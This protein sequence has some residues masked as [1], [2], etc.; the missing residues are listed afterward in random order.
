VLHAAQRG[1]SKSMPSEESYT[2]KLESIDA[3]FL[4]EL[5]DLHSAEKQLVSAL[6]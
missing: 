4:H 6:P 5:Q 2:M 3:L 1:A